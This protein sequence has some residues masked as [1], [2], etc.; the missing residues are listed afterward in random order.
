MKNF[1]EG[2]LF[3]TCGKVKI[4]FPEQDIVCRWCT[5]LTPDYRMDRAICKQT[6]EII[7]APDYMRGARCP[8]V[9]E[10]GDG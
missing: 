3:Y 8:I 4:A 7:P 2:V 10:E 5:L 1:S 6:G 9:F